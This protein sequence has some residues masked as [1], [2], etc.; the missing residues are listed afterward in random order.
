[1]ETAVLNR[2]CSTN[3]NHFSLRDF[4]KDSNFVGED[5]V[6]QTRQVRL[7][8]VHHY[9]LYPPPLLHPLVVSKLVL[10]ILWLPKQKVDFLKSIK[11]VH[12]KAKGK[13]LI[14]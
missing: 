2:K 14:W 10:C 6:S 8:I 9:H 1:M 3:L 11:N 12:H 13:L 5:I 4:F 7:W